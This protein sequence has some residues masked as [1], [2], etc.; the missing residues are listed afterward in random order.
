[1]AEERDRT[2]RYA[3]PPKHG[4]KGGIQD[5]GEKKAEAEIKTDE[6]KE[7]AGKGPTDKKPGAVGKV[8]EDK[9]PEAGKSPEFGVVAERHKAEHGA[10][11]KRHGEEAAAMHERHGKEGKDMMG[12][13]H[14]EMQDHMEEKAA[15]EEDASAGKPKEL[16]KEKGEGEKGSEA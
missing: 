12:R 4:K 1:M 14:K 13:H 16:G 8:G 9:G 15:G 7:G 11:T 2:K 5:K 3:N 10:M 6:H